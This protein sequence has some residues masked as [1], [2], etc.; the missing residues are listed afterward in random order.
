MDQ[1]AKLRKLSPIETDDFQIDFSYKISRFEVEF[2]DKEKE[3]NM[4]NFDKWREENGYG[5]IL[6]E[7]FEILK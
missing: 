5:D 3:D 2:K 1:I 4:K 7:Y 6:M